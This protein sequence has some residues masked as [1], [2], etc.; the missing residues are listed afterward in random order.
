[1]SAIDGWWQ[2]GTESLSGQDLKYLSRG[3]TDNSSAN[4][5]SEKRRDFR[6]EGAAG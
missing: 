3:F 5:W 4:L 6:K 2:R 1:M